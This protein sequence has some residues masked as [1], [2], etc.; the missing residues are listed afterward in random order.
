M[1]GPRRE[2]FEVES[3]WF[4][5]A[6]EVL[7]YEPEELLGTKLRA[8]Y[9]R[10]KGRDLF[11]LSEALTHITSLDLE[12]V[13]TFHVSFDRL[14]SGRGHGAAVQEAGPQV[15]P[16]GR[17]HRRM[18]RSSSARVVVRCGSLE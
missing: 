3:P 13:V 16:E 6:A 1:L 7:T 9:Q 18:D 8:L 4:T 10:K 12:K 11:D 14:A 15:R 2:R 5:G 17:R